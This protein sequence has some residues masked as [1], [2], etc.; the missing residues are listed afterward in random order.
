[1]ANGISGFIC[2]SVKEIVDR[3]SD[4]LDLDRLEVRRYAES[5]FSAATMARQYVRL[6][7]E[8]LNGTG[9]SAASTAAALMRA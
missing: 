6:Y 5:R 3:F 2:G 7:E 9:P 8:L 1:V 4:T